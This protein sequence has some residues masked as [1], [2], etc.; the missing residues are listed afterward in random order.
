MPSAQRDSRPAGRI[1][2]M[3]CAGSITGW[4]PAHD[5]LR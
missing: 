5:A 1:L 3:V 4:T 2:G